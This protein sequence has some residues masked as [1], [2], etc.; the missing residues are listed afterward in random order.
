MKSLISKYALEGKTDGAP[1][2]KFF[3]DK[4]A[5]AA[6]SSEVVG[7]HF[8]FKGEKKEKFL[9]GR[10]DPVWNHFDVLGQ[11]F[12]DVAKGPQFLRQLVD[13]N[14]LANGLQLQMANDINM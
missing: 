1:N 6:V 7:T 4:A 12:I 11:G 10:F 3:L 5:A 8:G 14:E 2:G 9:A 13:E